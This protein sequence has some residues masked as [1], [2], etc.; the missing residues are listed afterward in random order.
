MTEQTGDPHVLAPGRAPTPFTAEEVRAGCP[1][2]RTIRLRVDLAGKS[3]F[4]RVSRFVESDAAGATMERYLASSDGSALEEPEVQRVTWRDLQA[5]ASFDAEATTIRTERI[6]TAVGELEC[7]RY[8]VR[9]GTTDEV[10]WFAKDL[11]GMPV[12]VVTL[13]DGEVVATVSMVESSIR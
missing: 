11:P 9:D 7:L 3:P 10:F 1:A 12:Q 8:T 5:H 6:T 13:V 2:G 4:Y